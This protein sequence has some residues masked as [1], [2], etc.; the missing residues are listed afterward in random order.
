[1]FIFSGQTS[2]L[3]SQIAAGFLQLTRE[4]ALI[5]TPPQQQMTSAGGGG[6]RG[7][8]KKVNI[9]PESI[10]AESLAKSIL[11]HQAAAP[12]GKASVDLDA[13]YDSL[14]NESTGFMQKITGKRTDRIF[15]L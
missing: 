2:S 12:A 15:G 7:L 1:V 8:R 4:L 6:G 14:F 5:K 11:H 13:I 9:E 10:L 3:S